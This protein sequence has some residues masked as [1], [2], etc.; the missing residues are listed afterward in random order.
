MAFVGVEFLLNILVTSGRSKKFLSQMLFS[1]LRKLKQTLFTSN[2]SSILKLII[3]V[4]FSMFKVVWG[5]EK[6]EGRGENIY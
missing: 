1:S 6:K 3:P 5:L 2:M 4:L